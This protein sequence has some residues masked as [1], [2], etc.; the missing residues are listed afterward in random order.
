M[1][2]PDSIQ[3]EDFFFSNS[4]SESIVGYFLLRIL[5]SQSGICRLLL[6]S[7]CSLLIQS[8]Q[9]ILHI[10]SLS[11]NCALVY[12]LIIIASGLWWI[13]YVYNNVFHI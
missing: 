4:I 9:L 2:V 11:S 3:D 6:F 8:I 1:G 5:V 13:F 10:N 12:F 7:L